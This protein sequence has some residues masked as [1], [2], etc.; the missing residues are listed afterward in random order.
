MPISQSAQLFTLIKSMT[1]AEKR[2]FRLYARRNQDTDDMLFLQLFDQLD[3]QDRLDDNAVLRRMQ[4]VGKM[5]YSN[6]KRHLYTQIM[7]SMRL[8]NRQKEEIAIREL[9][10]FADILYARGL[11]LHSLKVLE[12]ARKAAAET[13]N[14]RLHLD[15]LEKEK[16]IESRHITRSGPDKPSALVAEVDAVNRKSTY[17][18]RLSNL[19]L[20]LHGDYIKYGHVKNAEDAARLRAFFEAN[21]PQVREDEL[22]ASE[23][24]YLYQSCVWYYFI[25]LDFSRCYLYARKWVDS[26]QEHPVLLEKDPD[27]YMRGYH[28]LL[29]AAYALHD[30][31]SFAE[32]LLALEAFRKAHYQKLNNNSR[33]LSFLYVHTGRLN[34]VFLTGRFSEGMQLLPSTLRRI[35]QY[36][37][38]LDNHRVLVFYFKIAW[39]YLGAGIPGKALD[40]LNKILNMELPHLREDIQGYAQLMFL[41]A[42]YDLRNFD[43]M[44]YLVRSVRKSFDKLKTTSVLQERTLAFFSEVCRLPLAER[45][46]HFGRFEKELAALRS[47]PYESRAF[48][49]L[50]IHLWVAAALE[51]RNMEQASAARQ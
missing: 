40:Y 21:M 51:G 44:D 49:Y 18:I 33:I 14:Y 10:D 30:E 15:V 1:K 4:G 20:L 19:R 7:S 25:L 45:K 35:Q 43:L 17:Q 27:L 48:I 12:K 41:M 47:D 5:Q 6:I 34:Q 28:Y 22:S 13:G 29:T 16:M 42:H 2:N 32:H 31:H 39:L 23:R 50:D 3:R 26:F 36:H 24:I 9:L 37:D 38:K 8:I 11:F 46:G